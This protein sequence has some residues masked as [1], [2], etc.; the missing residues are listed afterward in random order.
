MLASLLVL[1]GTVWMFLVIPKG[2]IPPQDT[3]QIAGVTEAAQ[4]IALGP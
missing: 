4:G 1:T 2:F 3:N